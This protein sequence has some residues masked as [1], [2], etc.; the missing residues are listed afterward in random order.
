MKLWD[1]IHSIVQDEPEVY[2]SAI[3]PTHTYHYL[4]EQVRESDTIKQFNTPFSCACESIT[5]II[6]VQHDFVCYL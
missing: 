5:L 4:I 1:T 2:Y 3:G 6:S